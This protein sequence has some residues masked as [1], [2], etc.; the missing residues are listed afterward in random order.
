MISENHEER[1]EFQPEEKNTF[2]LDVKK[3]LENWL[4]END[5]LDN[6]SVNVNISFAELGLSSIDAV[7]LVE[8]IQDDLDVK[9]DP[10]SAWRYPNVN[11]LS[12]HIAQLKTGA[13]F[14]N[15]VSI[16]APVLD[17]DANSEKDINLESM[18]LKSLAFELEKLLLCGNKN[19]K[20]ERQV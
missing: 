12:E 18:D 19:I 13:E 14:V 2:L 10:T 1:G 15:N 7:G 5:Y 4:E 16:D 17:D 3:Y 6:E 8:D 11:K 20:L 9:L